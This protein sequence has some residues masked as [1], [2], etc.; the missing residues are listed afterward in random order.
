[1][2][3]KNELTM[4]RDALPAALRERIANAPMAD[5]ATIK[6]RDDIGRFANELTSWRRFNEALL[7][8]AFTTRHIHTEYSMAERPL[9][10]ISDRYFDDLC[11]I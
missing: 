9:T 5:E 2:N 8:K 7:M 10:G 3:K 11:G 4:P 6:T 1:M